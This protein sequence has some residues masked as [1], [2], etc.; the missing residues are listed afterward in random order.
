MQKKQATQLKEQL[1]KARHESLQEM[2]ETTLR[3]YGKLWGMDVFSWYKPTTYLL[4]NTFH[5]FPYQVMWIGNAKD[6]LS[7]IKTDPSIGGLL[8]SVITIDDPK[9]VVD[10]QMDSNI[11]NVIGTNSVEEALGLVASLKQHDTILLFTASDSNWQIAK[12]TFESFLNT[13]LN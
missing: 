12:D 5:S 2:Q 8:H 7:V 6:I 10:T 11:E 1:L 3:P 9:M 13:E 4:L